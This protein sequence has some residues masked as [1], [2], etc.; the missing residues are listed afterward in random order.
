VTPAEHYTEAERLLDDEIGGPTP[1]QR[2]RRLVRAQVHATLA[3]VGLITAA[4]VEATQ[5]DNP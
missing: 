4:Q 1:E 3:T 2:L 5:G